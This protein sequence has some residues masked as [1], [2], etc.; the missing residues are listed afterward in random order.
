MKPS[1]RIIIAVFLSLLS[2]LSASAQKTVSILQILDTKTGKTVVVKEFPY[3]VEAP[4][5]TSDGK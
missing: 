1:A 2:G 4:N 3:T 5:W